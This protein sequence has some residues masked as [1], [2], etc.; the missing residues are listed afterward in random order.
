MSAIEYNR[1]LNTPLAEALDL[2]IGLLLQYLDQH[3]PKTS[4]RILKQLKEVRS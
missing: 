1:V 4:A 3:H 2:P